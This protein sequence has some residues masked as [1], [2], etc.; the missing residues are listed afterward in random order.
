[1]NGACLRLGVNSR[2]C[3]LGGTTY[4][5]GGGLIVNNRSYCLFN[6]LWGG[7]TDSGGPPEDTW[8]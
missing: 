2:L 1:M 7:F 8:N 6:F 4:M 3:A 5:G